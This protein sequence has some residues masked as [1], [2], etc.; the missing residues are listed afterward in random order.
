MPRK[1]IYLGC[2]S[3]NNECEDDDHINMKMTTC[4]LSPE[5][6]P[7]LQRKIYIPLATYFLLRSSLLLSFLV[8]Q[9]SF[10]VFFTQVT[11]KGKKMCELFLNLYFTFI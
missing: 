4:R 7:F 9:P 2:R 5:N 10:H 6:V 11:K 1:I 3:G 8:P